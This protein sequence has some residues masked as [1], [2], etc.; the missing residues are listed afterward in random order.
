MGRFL[1]FIAGLLVVALFSALLAPYFIDWTNF[2]QDFERQASSILGKKVVV[3]GDVSARII[4]FPSVTMKD[5]RV[6]QEGE[7]E[8]LVAVEQFSMDMELAPF[9]SGEARIFEM[10]IVRPKV[11]L[12]LSK[13]GTLDWI[14]TGNPTI[15][16]KT[17]VLENVHIIDGS[18]SFED[19]QTGRNRVV[20]DLDMVASAKTLRGPWRFE[21]EGALDGVEGRFSAATGAY[22]GDGQLRLVSHVSPAETPVE[23]DLEG[24]LKM[25]ALRLRYAGKFS[26]RYRPPENDNQARQPGPRASGNFELANDA[27]RLPDYR[28]EVGDPADPYVITGEATLDTGLKPEFLLTA[29]GQQVDINRIG[30]EAAKTGRYVDGSAWM[31]LQALMTVIGDVPIPTVPGRA[32]IKLPSIVAGDTTYRNIAIDAA[33]AGTGWTITKA[34][35]ELPGRTV[36]EANGN[37]NVKGGFGFDGQLVM[38]SNQPSGLAA[39]L[40]GRV[41]PAIRGLNQAGFSAS[42]SLQPGLQRFEGMELALGG[43]ILRGRAER[44]AL[45][46]HKPSISVDLSGG[47]LD[48]DALEALGNLV[49]G[50]D[51]AQGVL[52]HSIAAKLSFKALKAY[53]TVSNDVAT[54]FSLRDGVL[55]L[56]NLSVG[57]VLGASLQ[58]SGRIEGALDEPKIALDGTVKSEDPS[59]LLAYLQ[60]RLPDHPVMTRLAASSGF[61]VDSDLRFSV[62]SG[63]GGAWPVNLD[64]DGETNGTKLTGQFGSDILGVSEDSGFSFDISG[65]NSNTATLLG[66]FGLQP[67]PINEGSGGIVGLTVSRKAGKPAQIALSFTADDGSLTL[68]GEG[69]MGSAHF[70]DGRYAMTLESDDLEPYLIMTGVAVPQM[71]AG[72]PISLSASIA[73]APESIA[74][75]EVKGKADQNGFSGDLTLSRDA[76]PKVNGALSVDTLDVA[77]LAEAVIGPVTDAT[78]GW[79]SDNIAPARDAAFNAQIGVQVG[80]LW[81]GYALPVTAFDGTLVY[82]GRS[83]G[84][85]SGKGTFAGGAAEGSVSVANADGQAFLRAQFNVKN[86][87]FAK[88][89]WKF[90]DMPVLMGRSDFS[91]LLESSGRSVADLVSQFSGSGVV[92]VDPLTVTGLDL[93]V[94]PSILN[95]VD[96]LDEKDLTADTVA[97]LA[98]GIIGSG[99]STLGKVQ[100]PFS[101]S[102][103]VLRA[104]N[105]GA[106]TDNAKLTFEA[107]A[108][109]A[110]HS[111]DGSVRV[112]LKAGDE[113]LAGAE[114]AVTLKIG[115]E[116]SA[117]S[118]TLDVSE[119]AGFLSLRAFEQ[120]RRRVELLQADIMEKQRLRRENAYY[121]AL[122][123]AREA[124]RL[125]AEEEARKAQE[126][127]EK[128]KAEQTL[129]EEQK[130]AQPDAAPSNDNSPQPAASGSKSSN[131]P[132][133]AIDWKLLPAPGN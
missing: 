131:D 91:A 118:V 68:S 98:A 87:A 51:A 37:L 76:V 61:F 121:K 24:S 88:L 35:A 12:R 114:P 66:Q 78:G 70:L 20:S 74:F 25:E 22:D 107:D 83:V 127:E 100:V 90:G 133:G 79:N 108:N 119:L 67:L 126:A 54:T 50:G 84:L 26:A 86:A 49:F 89:S 40:S 58:A 13:D 42:V 123:E 39:W 56:D 27:V 94:L 14:R 5:V 28:I 4:P 19:Q 55:D 75:S 85:Q 15:P 16:A 111:I 45:G 7:T 102:G 117:P 3:Y 9:L 8:P 77:W 6:A 34:T 97:P 115:G 95:K 44:Q 32:T 109:L 104:S 47:E 2:R 11:R 38:A 1:V 124:A 48:I 105:V 129:Q 23:L 110:E 52:N 130:A 21:G 80:K 31:R 17:V 43:D 122:A 69:D 57:S 101:V 116:L 29:E 46:D 62:H 65:E 73:I 112:V 92:A 59:A 125:K 60:K 113:A 93:G 53:D 81:T 82:D 41:D 99:S 63:A 120:E 96:A 10:R 103:S 72:L 71:G 64:I 33:P 18:L 106:E 36:L 30:G 132:S 128:R